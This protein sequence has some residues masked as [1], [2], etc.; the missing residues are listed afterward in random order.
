MNARL[1]AKA[2][3]P[4]RLALGISFF[5]YYLF[6]WPQ[7]DL[8]YSDQGFAGF[9]YPQYAAWFKP[10]ILYSAWAIALLALFSFT[11]GFKTR[12]AGFLFLL[13]HVY[14]NASV[15]LAGWGWLRISKGLFLFTLLA[16]P[17]AFYSLDARWSRDERRDTSAPVWVLWLVQ[18]HL[19]CIYVAAAIH[20]VNDPGWLS[21]E[22]VFFAL[23]FSTYSRFPLVDFS[24]LRPF[25]IPVC[26]GALVLELAG[27]VGPWWGLVRKPVLGLLIVMHLGLE[28]TTTTGRWQTILVGALL[29][30]L[31]AN[32]QKRQ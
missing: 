26:W 11:L 13:V 9:F 27:I 21:G 14:F 25:L 19:S 6:S 12:T 32:N 31:A 16:N 28:I 8:L 4:L 3:V 24:A 22:M 17:G 30:V 7:L 10:A 29:T 1:S 18:L 5:C 20:R 15:E 2:F 23:D